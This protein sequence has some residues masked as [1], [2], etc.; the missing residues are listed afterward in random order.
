MLR[1]IGNWFS[2]LKL[3]DWITAIATTATAIFAYL[4][5]RYTVYASDPIVECEEPLWAKGSSTVIVLNVTI[6][7]K[8]TT[9]YKIKSIRLSK[10]RGALMKERDSREEPAR[11]IDMSWASLHPIGTTFHLPLSGM[12]DQSLADMG[13]T[14]LI[15][16]PSS[17]R[18]GKLRIVLT[19]ADKSFKP[20]S[21]RFVISKL[22][23]AQKVISTADNATK[24]IES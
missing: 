9:S 20:R 15:S 14:L 1:A 2:N 18:S 22:I 4:A 3:S 10:P 13:L 5:Y 6:R 17:F 24:L 16:V 12:G 8:S 19:L 7:N 23:Q 21:R 11:S